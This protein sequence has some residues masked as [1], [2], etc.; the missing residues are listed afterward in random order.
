M[1]DK[2]K[3]PVRTTEKTL[4]I[5]QT[6]KDLDGGG[7]T[8]IANELGFG[9]S[10]IHNH[11]S[12]LEEHEFVVKE[13]DAYQLSLRFME[14]GGYTRNRMDFYKT[15]K[16]EVRRLAEETGELANMATD[17]HGRCIY[18]YCTRGSNAVDLDTYA[19]FP[20]SMHNTA[21]GKSILAHL[22][23]S[24]VRAILDTRGMAPT[25]KNTITDRDVLFDELEEI[26]ERGYAFD[27]E[28]RLDGLRCVAAPV[29]R[30][31]GYVWGA[32]S[33]ASPTRRM[34]TERFEEE[35]PELVLGAANVI[36]INMTYS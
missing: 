30:E 13:D 7:V 8:E 26:R 21:L 15:A 19:G 23:E 35:I 14:L 16:D 12:T 18:L 4:Q 28:E 9:K 20:V 1:A 2:A 33:V 31:D 25:T 27:R 34:Q 17:E 10:T 32:I 6:L 24:E 22:P 29:K 36:Q 5:L 11:L 3:H